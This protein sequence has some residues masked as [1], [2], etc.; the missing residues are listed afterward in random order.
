VARLALVARVV[1]PIMVETVATRAQAET[2]AQQVT[3]QRVVMVVMGVMGVTSLP[4]TLSQPLTQVP[5]R[6]IST[7]K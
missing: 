6:M 3:V 4:A 1:Q 7:L 5:K 2:V